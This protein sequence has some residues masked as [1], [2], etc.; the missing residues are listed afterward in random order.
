M[1]LK[2]LL[3]HTALTVCVAAAA[4]H[5]SGAWAMRRTLTT[6]DRPETDA[7]S[8][9]CVTQG[10]V[11]LVIP[12][13]REQEHIRAAASWFAPLL[14]QMPGSTLTFVTTAREHTERALLADRVAAR[15]GKIALG[16]EFPQLSAAELSA[17]SAY[18]ERLVGTA[19]PEDVATALATA[20]A[21]DQV[22]KAVLTEPDF[23]ALPI[24]HVHYKGEGRKA[25]QVNCAAA[26][27]PRTSVPSYIGVYDIDSRPSGKLLRQ[28]WASIHA[29]TTRRGAAP[30]VV[31]QSARFTTHGL[32]ERGWERALCRGAARMQTIWTLRREIATFQ[33]YSRAAHRRLGP[34]PSLLTGGG[35][36]QTVGHGLWV[37]QDVFGELGGLPTYT[38]LDDLP[39]GYRLTVERVPLHVV[40]WTTTALGPEDIDTL[41]AQNRRWFNNYLDYA[42]CWADAE[43]A[44]RGTRGHNAAALLTGWYRGAMWLL[45]TPATAGALVSLFHPRSGTPLRAFA[46]AALWLGLVTPVNQISD[47]TGEQLTPGQR[48]AASLELLLAYLV[49][50]LGPAAAVAERLARRPSDRA[51]APKTHRRHIPDST[52]QPRVTRRGNDHRS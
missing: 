30:A 9:G 14:R 34:L 29:E 24:R 43:H 10:V 45:R 20:P 16:T 13:L 15:S 38:V 40:R 3:R 51:L 42:S 6:F 33:R 23:R 11:H 21:T 47:A 37:R 46:G 8:A 2:R 48:A 35:L 49:S 19:H 36:A 25:E 1:S 22:V 41:V 44:S 26:A 50:S 31:Q 7:P 52:V 17:V 39:F 5:A 28:T 4:R 18:F 27:L 12:V 32:S